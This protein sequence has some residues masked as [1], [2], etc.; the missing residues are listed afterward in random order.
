M[1]RG[2]K[3][4]Q[5]TS[6]RSEFM[7][8]QEAFEI[9]QQIDKREAQ[10]SEVSDYD[11][12][13]VPT[14]DYKNIKDVG[15]L[16]KALNESRKLQEEFAEKMRKNISKSYDQMQERFNEEAEESLKE[17]NELHKAAY[18]FAKQK[19]VDDGSIIDK[20]K[21]YQLEKGTL[22]IDEYV[23]KYLNKDDIEK[24]EEMSRVA[25]EA[26][27]EHK[28]RYDSDNIAIDPYDA[29]VELKESLAEYKQYAN[30]TFIVNP[31]D[32]DETEENYELDI[33]NVKKLAEK[34]ISYGETHG[35]TAGE[36]A[37]SVESDV[38]T[39]ERGLKDYNKIDKDFHGKY[40]ERAGVQSN[41]YIDQ[42]K[43]TPQDRADYLGKRQDAIYEVIRASERIVTAAIGNRSLYDG[44]DRWEQ[45]G[46]YGQYED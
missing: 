46:G 41:V 26:E 4:S 8:N 28:R 9:R 29:M 22:E 10:G 7:S 5:S 19:L 42:N 31:K 33:R 24:F 43:S 6:A 21:K 38:Y 34:M 3:Q 40:Y 16:N 35:E 15:E 2:N 14:P 25:N 44:L 39:L 12:Y 36:I 20:Y 45:R 13:D 37:S 1:A 30:P 32:N 11:K 17:V 18:D 23:D 27:E